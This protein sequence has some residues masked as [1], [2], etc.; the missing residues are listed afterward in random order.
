MEKARLENVTLDT[1]DANLF[2]LNNDRILQAK[3]IKYSILPKLNVILEESLSRIRRIYGIEVF[4]E[5]S[6]I[7]SWPNFRENRKN[8][9]KFNYH[10]AFI[11]IG[12]S[13]IPIW[14]GLQRIDKKPVKIMPYTLGFLFDKY[15]LTVLF[16]SQRYKLLLTN[17]SKEKYLDFLME[18]LQYI[19]TIGAISGMSPLLSYF[20]DDSN[21]V[22]PFRRLLEK[23]KDN[24]FYNLE[25]VNTIGFPIDY[26]RLNLLVDSFVYFYPI[27]DSLLK[28]SQNKKHNFKKLISKIKSDDYF[29]KEIEP[30]NDISEKGIE[31]NLNIDGIKFIRPGIRWQ[32]FDRDDFRCVAC[33]ISANEGAILHVDHILPRSKGG[34][35]EIDNYQTLCHLCNMGKSNKSNRNLRNIK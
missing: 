23:Y 24:H 30:E 16:Q 8:D 4:N 2:A 35:D 14:E 11:G 22:I 7:H 27:Y 19:Q 33:G 3:A 34:K 9:L 12:G 25:F 13:R 31:K 17:E 28:I 15:G 6:I 29:F 5:N 21:I 18:N 32:V 20:N 1:E 10:S 26:H